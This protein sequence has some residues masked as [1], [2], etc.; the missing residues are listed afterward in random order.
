MHDTVRGGVI[1]GLAVSTRGAANA[2]PFV[3]VADACLS[4]RQPE[5]FTVSAAA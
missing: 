5:W 2:C 4:P 3:D 1:A